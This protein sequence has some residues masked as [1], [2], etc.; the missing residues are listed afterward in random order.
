MSPT[1]AY[2]AAL[3]D[4]KQF[5]ARSKT[6]SGKFTFLHAAKIKT[7]I[8]VHGARTL[9]DYGCGKGV[10]YETINRRLQMPLAEFWGVDVTRYDPAWPAFAK[11]PSGQ[12]DIVIAVQVLGSVP[13]ADLPWVVDRLYGLARKALFIGERLGKP[14]KQVVQNVSGCPVG[15]TE[16]QWVAALRRPGHTVHAVLGT[17]VEVD[18]GTLRRYLDLT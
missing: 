3:E 5:H 9:L 17:R 2:A 15:W 16:A 13:I 4:C 7:L 18:G 8:D 11:E 12:F 14:K 10:Q 1:P 6:F